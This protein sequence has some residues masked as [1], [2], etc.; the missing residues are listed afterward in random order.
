MTIKRNPCSPNLWPGEEKHI[1]LLY[2]GIKHQMKCF[3]FFIVPQQPFLYS[4]H[5]ESALS[6]W[7][8]RKWTQSIL[9][10]SA[11]F[12]VKFVAGMSLK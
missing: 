4:C 3:C 11:L 8:Q 12:H 6:N 9:T 1:V 7:R 2:I 10:V 5:S